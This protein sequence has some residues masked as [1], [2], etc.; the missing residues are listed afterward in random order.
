MYDKTEETP[1]VVQYEDNRGDHDEELVEID[2]FAFRPSTANFLGEGAFGYVYR[3]YDMSKKIDRQV[4][5]KTVLSEKLKRQEMELLSKIRSE[6]LV[7][8]LSICTRGEITYVVMELCDGD[9]AGYLSKYSKLDSKNATL[10]ADNLARG[11]NILQAYKIVH[12]DIKPQNILIK[13]RRTNND[14]QSIKIASEHQFEDCDRRDIAVAKLSDFGTSHLLTAD[15]DELCNVAG[16][17]FYMAPEVGANLVTTNSYDHSADMWSIGCVLYESISGTIPFDENSLC[18][19]FLHVA[20]KNYQTFAVKTPW[21][22]AATVN[23]S[24][25]SDDTHQFDYVAN[26]LLKIDPK[27]RMT[28]QQFYNRAVD[29]MSKRSLKANVRHRFSVFGKDQNAH[30]KSFTYFN[31]DQQQKY[32]MMVDEQEQKVYKSVNYTE[33]YPKMRALSENRTSNRYETS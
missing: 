22:T 13:Y 19:L 23:G 21:S 11:Y 10:L 16:T 29:D 14:R 24:Y 7:K 27:Q 26:C 31:K 33:E 3:G 6:H 15:D 9:L 8:I 12:R 2:H 18:R 25:P 20:C 28:P 30:S 4:A 17:L 1:V 5:I 32:E